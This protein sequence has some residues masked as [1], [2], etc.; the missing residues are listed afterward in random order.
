[1]KFFIASKNSHKIDEFVRI[2]KPL[3]IEVISESDLDSPLTEV[4]ET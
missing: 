4:E 3:N 1:M 2:L